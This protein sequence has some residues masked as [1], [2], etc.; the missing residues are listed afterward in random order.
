MDAPFALLYYGVVNLLWRGN[1]TS[2]LLSQV[3][4]RKHNAF[5]FPEHLSSL[6]STTAGD[7]RRVVIEQLVLTI[8]DPVARVLIYSIRL[9]SWQWQPFLEQLRCTHADTLANWQWHAIVFKSWIKS[10]LDIPY[11]LL[12]LVVIITGWRAHHIIKLTKV[13]VAAQK[14]YVLVLKLTN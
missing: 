1:L 2:Y 7:R 5:F 3:R 10:L 14:I 6:K 4:F 9:L 11:I 13:I 8:L 12:A